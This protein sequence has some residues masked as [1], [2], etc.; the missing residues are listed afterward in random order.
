MEKVKVVVR[1]IV[2]LALSLFG[3]GVDIL[4]HAVAVGRNLV[5]GCLIGIPAAL[6]MFAGAATIFRWD[7]VHQELQNTARV[8]TWLARQVDKAVLSYFGLDPY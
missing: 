8:V 5:L 6:T 1:V 3:L 2:G 7:E 4:A